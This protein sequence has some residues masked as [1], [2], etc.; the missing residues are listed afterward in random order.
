MRLTH[1]DAAQRGAIPEILALGLFFRVAT[2]F[3]L[4]LVL[5]PALVAG[6][7]ADF[8]DVT[9]LLPGPTGPIALLVFTTVLA[10]PVRLSALLALPAAPIFFL[11][12][13]HRRSPE[14]HNRTMRSSLSFRTVNCRASFHTHVALRV[15]ANHSSLACRSN[16]AI[17]KYPGQDRE[18][19][20]F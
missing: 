12:L 15:C 7:A 14:T 20:A 6:V 1:D 17:R 3:L 18:V 8:A 4:G 2:L 16:P 5:T 10:R 11:R 13:V 19:S 9:T